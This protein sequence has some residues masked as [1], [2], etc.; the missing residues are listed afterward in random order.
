[1][2]RLSGKTAVITGGASGIGEATA[3]LF[4]EEGAHVVIADL[5]GDRAERLAD[6]LGENARAITCNVTVENDVAAAVG[7]AVDTWG[8]LD[9]MFNN[10][11]IIG[12]VGSIT[13][14]D[15]ARVAD[16]NRRASQLG[17]LR[18]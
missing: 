18:M 2:G 8:R 12:A 11:G 15:V 4:V 13:E 14:T 3:R 9:V 6:A 16:D 7:L 5:Q 1:M 17:V 10:A